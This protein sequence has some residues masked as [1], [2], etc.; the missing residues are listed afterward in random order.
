MAQH[1]GRIS[2]AATWNG[3]HF[4]I[5]PQSQEPTRNDAANRYAFHVMLNSISCMLLS[6]Q[7]TMPA[8]HQSKDLGNFQ[9]V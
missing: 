4:V 1:D 9:Q 2:G 5:D 7:D 8:H 3:Q 6:M